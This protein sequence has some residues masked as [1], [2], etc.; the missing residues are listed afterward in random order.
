MS[1]IKNLRQVNTEELLEEF[2]LLFNTLGDIHLN[3]SADIILWKWTPS[4]EYTA[5]SAYEA[6]FLGAY[7]TFRASSIWRAHTEPKCRFLAW[8]AL[9]GKIPTTDNLIKKNWPCSPTCAM[10]YC[11]AETSDHILT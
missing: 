3:E 11:E 8:L 10:C 7:P 9:L 6:Q 5:A 2:I 4:E 1:W